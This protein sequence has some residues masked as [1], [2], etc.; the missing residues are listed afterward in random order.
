MSRRKGGK[1]FAPTKKSNLIFSISRMLFVLMVIASFAINWQSI[2]AFFTDEDFNN[3]V[4]S[5]KAYYDIDFNSNDENN[6]V[7]SQRLSFNVETA[8][9]ANTFI[10]DGYMFNGWNTE[11]DGSGESFTDEQLVTQ[12]SFT[13][14]EDT[15]MLYAQWIDIPTNAVATVNGRYYEKL[16]DAIDAVP[17]DNTKTTVKL[18]KNVSEALTVAAGQNILFNFQSFTVS[19]QGGKNVIVNDGSI[20]IINGTIRTNAN[21]GAINNNAGATLKMSG[22]SIISTG[23]RQAIYNA[24]IVEISGS[25]YLSSSCADNR[26]TLHNLASGTMTVTGGTIISSVRSGIYNLG[27]LV[28]GMQDNDPNLDS[29]TIQA[30]TYGITTT[31]DIS[32]YGG[33]VKGKSNAINDSSRITNLENNYEIVYSTETISGITYKTMFLDNGVS[34][35]FDPN[36]GIIEEPVRMLNNGD[37]IGTLPIP[38]YAEYRFDGWFTAENGGTQITENMIINSS[39]TV[40][41][42]W[43]EQDVAEVNG[44]RYHFLQTAIDAVPNNTQTVV[45]VLEKIRVNVTVETTKNIVFDLSGVTLTADNNQ[46]VINNKGTTTITNGTIKSNQNNYAAI[47][48]KQN[49]KLYVTGGTIEA[50]GERQAIYNERGYVEIS[51]NPHLSSQAPER[52]TVQNIAA[53][54]MV[55]KGGT[56]ISYTQQAVNNLGTMTIGT[57][58]GTINTDLPN[59]QGNTYG[60]INEGTLKFYDGIAKGI[61]GSITGTIS[62]IEDNSHRTTSTEVISGTTY[63]TEYLEED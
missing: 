50:T 48:N 25:A 54:T 28:V 45:K 33:T 53:S 27:T 19:D 29:P 49:A 35:I 56:I 38:E 61:T 46:P 2:L 41:A 24:G 20:E 21:Q 59:M 22:G 63:I 1:R 32:F 31:T 40:Y 58:D 11:S 62:E 34:V 10:R 6:L 8:L 42:H 3:N 14:F 44:V 4:F 13:S 7:E 26:G 36:G 30:N 5:I 52:S 51:G 55:I 17:T 18:L 60:I 23:N 12:N 9:M 15:N 37:P 39:T 16:Q 43:S 57:K 47:D